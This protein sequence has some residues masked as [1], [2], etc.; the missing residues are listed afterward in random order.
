MSTHSSRLAWLTGAAI[1]LL[2]P[3]AIADHPGVHEG[4]WEFTRQMSIPGM[5][6]Q[7]PATTTKQCVGAKDM[8]PRPPKEQ[9]DCEISSIKVDGNKVSWHVKCTGKRSAEGD[10]QIT[11]GKDSVEG[12]ATFKMQH[13]RS[14][15]PI[16]ATQTIKGRRIG[17]CTPAK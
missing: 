2:S 12:S 10:G 17:D 5:P 15:Q 16:E 11:Y 4:E 7:P 3:L 8:V 6:F 14:G 9:G 13:P 1:L